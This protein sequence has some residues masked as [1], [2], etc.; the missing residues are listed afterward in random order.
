[1]GASKRA[2]KTTDTTIKRDTLEDYKPVVELP[3]KK[4]N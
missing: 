1:M 2:F 4:K 3:K